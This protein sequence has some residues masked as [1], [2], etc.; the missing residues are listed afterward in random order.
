MYYLKIALRYFEQMKFNVLPLRGKIPFINWKVW[1][2]KNQT[3][4]DIEA[5]DW[6]Y[7]SGVGVVMGIKNVRCL[8]LDMVENP[9]LL[10]DILKEL[11]LPK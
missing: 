4:E 1:Q 8:D 10:D 5:M 3:K 9:D 2:D 7:S 6:K 11:N